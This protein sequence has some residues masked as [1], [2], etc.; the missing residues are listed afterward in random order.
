MRV[1]PAAKEGID[2]LKQTYNFKTYND[3]ITTIEHFFKVSNISPR[4]SFGNEYSKNITDF[5][6]EMNS[7]F[8][9]LINSCV[10]NAERI[11]NINREIE[12]GLLKPIHSNIS[13]IHVYS[14]ALQMEKNEDSDKIKK[15]EK[16]IFDQ[17]ITIRKLNTIIEQQ[18]IKIKEY[19]R[20]L[21]VLDANIVMEKSFTR[22][23]VMINLPPEEVS[24]LF[25][26]IR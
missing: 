17:S 2:W 22:K 21:T 5:R 18:E 16:Q 7:K 3:C 23:T 12:E 6:Q 10:E 4:E 9:A 14:M 20:C 19:N 25:H 26:L 1:S 8:D 13:D 15:L 11:I 24:G